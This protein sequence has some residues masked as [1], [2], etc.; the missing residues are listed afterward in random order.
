MALR[1]TLCAPQRQ[2]RRGGASGALC[3]RTA[4]AGASVGVVD[5]GSAQRDGPICPVQPDRSLLLRAE[6]TVATRHQR[7]HRRPPQRHRHV[8]AHP[9]RSRPGRLLTQHR[10]SGLEFRDKEKG[11]AHR[12]TPFSSF[13]YALSGNSLRAPAAS[14][15][16]RNI[17]ARLVIDQFVP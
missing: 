2:Q 11:G 12:G 13:A 7:G 9:R 14:R 1:H 16:E 10:V 3:D 4:F 15:R 8:S 6:L 17:L 5:L